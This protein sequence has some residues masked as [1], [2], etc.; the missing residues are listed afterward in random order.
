MW[1][2]LCFSVGFRS[3]RSTADLVTVASDKIGR[4]YYSS[5]ATRAV[6]LDISKTFGRVWHAGLLHKLKS[7]GISRSIVEFQ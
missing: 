7:Y 1:P 2:F 6:A 4:A 3:S 5:G